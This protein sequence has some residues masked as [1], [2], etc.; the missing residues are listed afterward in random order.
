[1]IPKPE[2]GS[3][4]GTPQE[5]VFGVPDRG[6]ALRPAGTSRSCPKSG[7]SAE[8]T[9]LEHEGTRGRALLT[10][11]SGTGLYANKTQ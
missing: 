8:G 7:G 4:G 11:G 9:V 1:M 2:G 10:P 3:K 5:G 6:D